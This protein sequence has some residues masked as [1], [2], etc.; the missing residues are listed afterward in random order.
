MTG[1]EQNHSTKITADIIKP[2]N[3]EG[4]VCICLKKLELVVKLTGVAEEAMFIPLYLEGG[5][6]AVYMEMEEADQSSA[7]KI[8]KIS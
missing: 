8:K 1:R 5:A 6:L 7:S 2:F 4:D 3:G